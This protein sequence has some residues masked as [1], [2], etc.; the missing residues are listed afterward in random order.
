MF[1]SNSLKYSRRVSCQEATPRRVESLMVLLL[2]PFHTIMLGA[3]FRGGIWHALT[4]DGDLLQGPF[5]V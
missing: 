5:T 1:K 2:W 4:A 3:S